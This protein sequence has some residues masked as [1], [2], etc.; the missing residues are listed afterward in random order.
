MGDNYS[1]KTL[2]LVRQ[3]GKP[4]EKDDANDLKVYET[5]DT[6]TIDFIQKNGTRQ[7]FAYSHMLTAWYGKEN[8]DRVVKVFFATHTVTIYGYCLEGIYEHLCSQNIKSVKAHDERY[9][10]LVQEGNPF[11]IR[12]K[13]EWRNNDN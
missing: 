3:N 4:E 6:R 8:E 9:S 1:F 10:D 7:C 5:G 13:V 12:L 2:T 11:I